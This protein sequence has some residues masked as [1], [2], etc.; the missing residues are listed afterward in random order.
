M[1]PLILE[2]PIKSPLVILGH[3][4]QD[5]PKGLFLGILKDAGLTLE[6]FREG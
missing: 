2:H 3:R 6:E 4:G 5:V 1:L